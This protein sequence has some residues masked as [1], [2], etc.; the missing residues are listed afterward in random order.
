MRKKG[1]MSAWKEKFLKR[2][3]GGKKQFPEVTAQNNGTKWKLIRGLENVYIVI[4]V[5][6]LYWCVQ[7]NHWA[8]VKLTSSMQ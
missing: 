5:L 1:R 8:K 3:I 4:L 6:Q 7:K 2:E